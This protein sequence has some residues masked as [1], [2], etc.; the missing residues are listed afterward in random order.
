M[1]TALMLLASATAV[2]KQPLPTA[3]TV[4][5]LKPDS[6]HIDF[7]QTPKSVIVSLP[8]ALH[9]KLKGGAQSDVRSVSIT[10]QNGEHHFF[11]YREKNLRIQGVPMKGI[12]CEET[13]TDDRGTEYTLIKGEPF[14]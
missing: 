1:L 9:P 14:C 4:A 8:R 6:I 12:V 3:M 13:F 10:M 5:M 7:G 11:L 2:A